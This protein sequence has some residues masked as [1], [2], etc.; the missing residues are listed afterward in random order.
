MGRSEEGYLSRL[1]DLSGLDLRALAEPKALA[2]ADRQALAAAL[3]R[4]RE[5]GEAAQDSLL[6][7]D[8]P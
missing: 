2:E 7:Q 5:R 6:Y 4:L 8:S 3:L 1:P